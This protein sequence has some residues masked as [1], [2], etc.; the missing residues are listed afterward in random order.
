MENKKSSGIL[1]F[2]KVSVAEIIF[3]LLL[4]VLVLTTLNYFKI[5][6]LSKTFP[7]LSFLPSITSENLKQD[8]TT[9]P[10]SSINRN[11]NIKTII[12]PNAPKTVNNTASEYLYITLPDGAVKVAGGI[13]IDVELYIEMGEATKS[14]SDSSAF[15]F[16]NGLARSRGDFRFLRLFFWPP[17]KEWTVL[18]HHEGTNQ[19]SKPILIVSKEPADKAY[20]KFSLI[21]SR[22]G[23]SVTT[24]SPT[25]EQKILQLDDSLY[26]TTNQMFSAVQVAPNSKITIISLS[27]QHPL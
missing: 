6:S 1:E 26:T 3:V 18:Y 21:I 7:F 9:K 19:Y 17:A 16:T 24:I 12:T 23:K 4:V 20:G 22:D 14:S 13:R 27:Y 10:T 5:I 11:S 15:L 8:R 2:F 25:G